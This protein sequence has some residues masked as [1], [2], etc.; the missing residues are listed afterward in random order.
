MA[1]DV[2][3]R[4]GAAIRS[5]RAAAGMT[6]A[7]LASAA[8]LARS[9]ITNI[10]SGGQAILLHQLLDVARALKAD[11]CELLADVGDGA[12][13]AVATEAQGV[14]RRARELL[15]LLD[16]PIRSARR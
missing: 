15:G 8:G 1:G 16:R 3:A 10:E 14:D 11:P 7:A 12:P 2:Y 9:S 6:Q 4:L 13:P 5:R